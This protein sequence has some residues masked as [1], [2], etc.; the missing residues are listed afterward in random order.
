LGHAQILGRRAANQYIRA[1]AH[2]C[3]V[4]PPQLRLPY[5]AGCEE[6]VAGES[7]ELMVLCRDGAFTNFKV[8]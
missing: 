4:L 8:S 1:A 7:A 6:L 2:P 3:Y 5:V